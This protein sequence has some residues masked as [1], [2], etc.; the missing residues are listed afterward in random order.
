MTRCD[1]SDA[2][3]ERDGLRVGDDVDARCALLTGDPSGVVDELSPDA[4]PH[5]I[6]IDEQTIK[7]AAPLRRG[8]QDGEPDGDTVQFGH[9]DEARGDLL[10]GDLD[11][12][13]M[14]DEL[15]S[16]HRAVHRGTALEV[17]EPLPIRQLSGAQRDHRTLTLVNSC[18]RQPGC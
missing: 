15:R 18:T 6:R 12:I 13:G 16:V 2:L 7:L 4:G 3:V 17:L 10:R 9:T 8:Q 5:P 11:R 1:E 14:R